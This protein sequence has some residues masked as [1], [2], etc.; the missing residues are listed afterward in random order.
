MPLIP[1]PFSLAL[2]TLALIAPPSVLLVLGVRLLSSAT[3]YGALFLVGGV[4]TA[5]ISVTAFLPSRALN[6]R[7]R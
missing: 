7:L 2:A 5:A 3:L 1:R 4:V 6:R